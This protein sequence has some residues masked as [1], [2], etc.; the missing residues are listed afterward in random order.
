MQ[1]AVTLTPSR[2]PELLL[3]LATVRPVFVC[4]APGIGKSSLVREFA[5]SLGLEPAGAGVPGPVS[6]AARPPGRWPAVR[7]T[8]A[9]V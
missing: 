2:M 8:G 1:A 3:G 4:G 5:E 6:P 9:R 7:R